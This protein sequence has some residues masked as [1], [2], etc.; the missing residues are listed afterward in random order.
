MVPL[1]N[2]WAVLLATASSMVVGS[3]WYARPVF[4]KYWMK[5]VGHTEETMRTGAAFSLII[6]VIVS[7][8]T[9]WVLSG[10]TFIAWKFYSGS[11]LASA[12]LTAIILWLGFTAA[13]MITHDAFDRRPWGLTI[14][15]IVHEFVTL[16][17]MA[18]IIGLW[19]PAGA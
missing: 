6:A 15:N 8:I 9:A 11:F 18:L 17:I 2:Y 12:L 4:G 7:F 1:I 14:L 13:R 16:V 5:A 19:P 10:A 3:I